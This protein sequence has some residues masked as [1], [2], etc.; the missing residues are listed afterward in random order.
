MEDLE[1]RPRSLSSILSQMNEGSLV[2]PEFQR[3]FVWKPSNTVALLTSIIKDY[4]AGNLLFWKFRPEN[5]L[6]HR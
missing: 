4:P 2:I 3:D 5:N 1:A 6:Q